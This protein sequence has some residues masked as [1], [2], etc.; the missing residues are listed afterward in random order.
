MKIRSLHF[1]GISKHIPS[2]GKIKIDDNEDRINEE[3]ETL[4]KISFTNN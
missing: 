3:W 2:I 4:H 1:M